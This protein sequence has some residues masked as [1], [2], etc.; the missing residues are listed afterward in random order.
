MQTHDNVKHLRDETAEIREN[1][2][3]NTELVQKGNE[4]REEEHQEK[5]DHLNSIGT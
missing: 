2:T 1:V 3:R 4:R 5:T